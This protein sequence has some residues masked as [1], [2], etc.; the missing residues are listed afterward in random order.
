MTTTSVFPIPDQTGHS[1]APTI[2]R[3]R[4]QPDA[5]RLVHDWPLARGL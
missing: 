1:K 3:D 4:P 2:S 5:R